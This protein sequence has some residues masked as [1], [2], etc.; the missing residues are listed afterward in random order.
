MSF[1]KVF[2]L[3]AWVY[4]NFYNILMDLST[5]CGPTT[6]LLLVQRVSPLRFIGMNIQ[7]RIAVKESYWHLEQRK[8]A[9][10]IG[11]IDTA[12]L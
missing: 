4:F 11:L 8:P 7:S 12:L 6:P 2:D 1:D 9:M 3:T 10:R 5:C